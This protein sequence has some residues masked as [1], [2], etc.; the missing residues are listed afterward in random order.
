[1]SAIFSLPLIL[2]ML[3]VFALLMAGEHLGRLIWRRWHANGSTDTQDMGHVLTSIYGLLA[4]LVAFTFGMAVD[5]Y[6]NRRDLV[7]QEANAI[8]TAHIR[9]GFAVDPYGQE[10]RDWLESYAEKRL[11]FGQ[12]SGQ[13]RTSLVKQSEQMRQQIVRV[14]VAASNNVGSAPMGPALIDSVNTVIDIGSERE[15]NAVA[16]V[17]LTV[18][19]LLIAYAFS[20]AVLLGHSSE[21]RGRHVAFANA[22]LLLLLTLLLPIWIDLPVEQLKLVNLPWNN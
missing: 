5:R 22:L 15:A 2:L 6:E 12:A 4:L 17:P 8:G 10:L 7:I 14:G 13:D 1:M 3:M 19:W 11:A 9:A 18:A 20:A 16:F 21:S